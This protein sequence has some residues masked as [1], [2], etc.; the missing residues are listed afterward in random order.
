MEE[1]IINS[2]ERDLAITILKLQIMHFSIIRV[3][4]K[5]FSNYYYEII[6]TK[7]QKWKG[8]KL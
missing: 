6:Y 8:I 5:K 2:D 4:R 7:E 1:K 3:I